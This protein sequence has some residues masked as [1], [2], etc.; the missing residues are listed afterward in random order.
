M[1]TIPST[2]QD[3]NVV[4]RSL[5]LAYKTVNERLSSGMA[6]I[7]S[8]PGGPLD[9]YGLYARTAKL[10]DSRSVNA[11]GVLNADQRHRIQV[12]ACT[13]AS[14][15]IIAALLAIYWFCMMRRNYR[16]DLVLMLILGDFYKSLWYV[17][18]GS[19]TFAT[20]QVASEAPFCQVSG[21]MLGVG[22]E[23]C[24]KSGPLW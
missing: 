19:V 23:S 11:T 15:S 18:Y 2:N 14:I 12:I 9:E 16:R 22:L 20:G 10:G 7:D 21:F 13:M 17:I 4:R 3:P 8:W 24:G 1:P 5:E 6:L